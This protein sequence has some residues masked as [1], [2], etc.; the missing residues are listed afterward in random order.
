MSPAESVPGQTRH[1]L[2]GGGAIIEFAKPS[3]VAEPS[4]A[5]FASAVLPMD[6]LDDLELKPR[7]AFCGS[8]FRQ[9][10][11]GFIFGARGLGKTWLAM[12]CARGLAEGRP[13]GPWPVT[14]SRRVLYIDGEMPIDGLRERNQLLRAGAGTL[15]VLN[16]ELL[17]ERTEIVLNL[18]VKATQDRITELAMAKHYDVVFLDN[19]SCLFAGVAEN[20]ADAWEAV[21]PWLLT[22]RRKKI[23][24]VI[25]HHANRAGTNMRGTSRREDAAFWMLRLDPV[26]DQNR[27]GDGARFVSRFTKNRQ[28]TAEETTPLEWHYVTTGNRVQATFK[29]MQSLD[30]FRQWLRDGLT[31]CGEIAEEMG[32]TKGAVSKLAKRAEREG[33]LTISNRVY[34]LKEGA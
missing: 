5:A 27:E 14:Q 25:V 33:W 26:P 22:L 30:V 23:A 20:D 4:P 2:P 29:Q 18:S 31:G 19:L 15:D 34:S 17:F 32:M 16:H 6:G 8:W 28:G 10:D 21:L 1:E 12:D 3:P 7:E 9:G 13:V 11:L 24:V